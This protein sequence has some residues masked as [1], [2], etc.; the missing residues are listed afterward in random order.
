[1]SAD[2]L[3]LDFV[4][5]LPPV[6][7]GIADYSAD[8]LPHL[9]PLADLRLVHL[10]G[11]PLDPRLA[12]RY[13]IVAPERLGEDGRLPVYQ[14][15]NNP[16]HEAVWELAM[17]RPGVLVLHD[18]VLHHFLIGRTLAQGDFAAYREALERDHGWIGAAAARVLRWPGAAS[19]A[20][21]FSLPAN[22]TL[23]TRQ[24]GVV[25]HSRWAAEQ[26][27]E[28]LPE[29]ATRVVPMAVP[30]GRAASEQERQAFRHRL[31]LAET[32]PVLGA[33]G[34][35]TPIK[36]TDVA[37]A[38]LA[39]PGLENV[40]L[41]VAGQVAPTFELDRAVREA[42][43][44]ERV[45]FLGFLPFDQLEAA[46]AATDL[47]LNLRYP[48]AGETSAS[49]LRILAVGRPALVS[50]Y[51]PSADLDSEAVLAVP[52]GEGEKEVLARR[53]A[54]RLADPGRLRALGAAARRYVAERHDPARTAIAMVEACRSL[55][56]RAPPAALPA[57]PPWPASLTWSGLPTLTLEGAEAP[58]PA[59]ER[60]RLA[61]RLRNRSDARWLA[62][63]RLVGGVAI[64]I[65]VFQNGRNLCAGKSW[66]GLPRDLDPGEE[67][68][69]FFDLRRPLGQVRV[70]V[71]PHVLG[72]MQAQG[73][74]NGCP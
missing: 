69:L 41:I 26:L 30:L 40:H 13:P 71:V 53:V 70:E 72:S 5:P 29:V 6:R 68:V 17:E 14:M 36:R 55:G 60:R 2:R 56:W 64:E 1:M 44:E 38:A 49:L 8:L 25:T 33:F 39:E 24:R 61:I 31:G 73:P 35:Q 16:Y 20:I 15:G 62:G 46:I 10:P 58:W 4:S 34:F 51:G 19:D 21:K 66:I 54:E 74:L 9:A 65:R 28:E 47:C 27:A 3:R 63:E 11:Q 59:G 18:F 67:H 45:H 12:E 48:T 32:T 50:E 43:V 37:I 23:L 52:L 7:S 57:E 22:R 42:G